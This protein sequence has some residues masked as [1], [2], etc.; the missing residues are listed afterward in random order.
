MVFYC[1]SM[2]YPDTN[3]LS[4]LGDPSISRSLRNLQMLVLADKYGMF[5]LRS[6]AMSKFVDSMHS[7]YGDHESGR[8]SIENLISVASFVYSRMP[9]QSRAVRVVTCE[10]VKIHWA[11]LAVMPDLKA[12][13]REIPDFGIDMVTEGSEPKAR[14]VD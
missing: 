14:E 4:E 12:L 6:T 2:N 5:M 11:K 9:W 1:Y 13:I 8:G 3:Y 7:E 10:I